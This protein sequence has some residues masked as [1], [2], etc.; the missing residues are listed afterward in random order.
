M[1]G[2]QGHTQSKQPSGRSFLLDLRRRETRQERRRFA[3]RLPDLGRVL[4]AD[5]LGLGLP[6][7][8]TVASRSVS[9]RKSWSISG[10]KYGK[11]RRNK[12]EKGKDALEALSRIVQDLVE[13]FTG[14]SRLGDIVDPV[15][16][17]A[18]HREA[19]DDE[20]E[21]GDLGRRRDVV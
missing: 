3:L 5:H 11:R 13:G 19:R 6:D 17:D 7:R 4:D 21:D 12:K 8:T 16:E 10:L 15:R 1:H 20:R 14:Q 18:V 9:V 2:L